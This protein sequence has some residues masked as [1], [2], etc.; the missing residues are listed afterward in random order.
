MSSWIRIFQKDTQRLWPY[1]LIYLALLF[2]RL[3]SDPAYSAWNPLFEN[4]HTDWKFLSGALIYAD[5]IFLMAALIH[6]EALVGDRQYWLTRPLTRCQLLIS[7]AVFIILYILI[8]L[9][10]GHLSVLYC[11]GFPAAKVLPALLAKEIIFAITIVLPAAA[12]ASVTRNFAQMV[13]TG[14]IGGILTAAVPWHQIIYNNPYWGV[15][16]WIPQTLTYGVILVGALSV[17]LI[18]YMRRRPIL[19]RAVSVITLL[20]ACMITLL[21]PRSWA[22]SIQRFFSEQ[23]AENSAIQLTLAP[24]K[25]H[26]SNRL[27]SRPLFPESSMLGIPIQI[28][29]LPPG[30]N[31]QI[32]A[33]QFTVHTETNNK[34]RSNWHVSPRV[35]LNA[36]KPQL[37][38]L[39]D[40]TFYER[41]KDTPVNITGSIDAILVEHHPI[42]VHGRTY[43]PG[44]GVFS[45]T[46]NYDCLTYWERAHLNIEGLDPNAA[47]ENFEVSPEECEPWPTSFSL[48]PVS[49][50]FCI[51]RSIGGSIFPIK[52]DTLSLVLIHPVAHLRLSFTFNKILP[53][54]YLLQKG[55]AS[56]PEKKSIVRAGGAE[57][58]I[59]QGEA[60]QRGAQPRE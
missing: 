60:P 5:L 43:I 23:R 6:Q 7:K 41:V 38:L 49:S 16:T 52:T 17:L 18:Q 48:T 57:R 32:T 22:A 47:Q 10:I 12:L 15:F 59:A 26:R 58:A 24:D 37:P 53:R 44:A 29:G 14:L 51:N 46:D 35:L 30:M 27:P 28:K 8:P 3:A 55:V 39:V 9:F 33:S 40:S 1:V 54:D 21:P 19:A 20:V 31:L 34:W 50:Y 56:G 13:L 25:I 4:H 2:L 11:L 36:Q 45:P 42:Q